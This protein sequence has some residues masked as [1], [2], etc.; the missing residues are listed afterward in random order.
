MATEDILLVGDIGGTNTRLQL[1][2][3]G[4]AVTF[5]EGK[6]MKAPG[7]LVH[8]QQY[9]NSEYA[10]FD[11]VVAAFMKAANVTVTPASACFAVAGPVEANR[12]QFTNRDWVIDGAKL[13]AS[14]G[15]S[16]VRLIN[17]FVAN[18]Y[19]LLTLD[20]ANECVSLQGAQKVAGAPIACIGAGTGL[21]ECFSTAVDTGAPYESYP[22]EGGHAE[23]SP[24]S[25]LEVELLDFMKA[26]FEQKHRVSVERVISGPGLATMYEFFAQR[27][28]EKVVSHV[29]ESIL[30]A[31]EMKGKVIS[32][33]ARIGAA[34]HCEL[35][36]LVMETFASAYG[37]EAGVAA[38]KWIPLGGLYIAGGLTPKNLELIQ[39]AGSPFMRAF[40]DKGRLSP[41][42]KRVPVYAVLAEDIGQ[43]GAHLVAFRLTRTTGAH[44]ESRAQEAVPISAR[45]LKSL[46]SLSAITTLFPTATQ[47]EALT[48]PLRAEGLALVGDIGGTN[49][50]L[51]LYTI[52]AGAVQ[53]AGARA[54]GTLVH[55]QQ[56]LNSEY[57]SFDAVVAAFMKA[58]N[59][60][61]TPASACFAVAG[62]VE[63]NRVQFTNRDWVIDGAKLEASL[64]ISKVRLINDFVANGYG[65]LTLDEANECVSLQGAQ[66][67]AGAPIACIGAGTGL[68][69]CF[70]T[71]VDTGAP[72]ESYPSEG[73]HAEWSPRSAL[74]VELLDFMKAKFEQKHRVSVERVISGPGLATMYEFF[75]QR[76]PEKVV[77]HVHESILA[78]GEMKGKVISTH[79]RIGAAPHC[80]LCE[81]VMETFA[82]AYGAEAGVAALKWIPLGGLYIA[83]GLTPKNLELIQGAGSPFMRAFHDKGRLSPLLKR[84]PVYAVLAEDIGQRGAHL[85]AFRLLLKVQAEVKVPPMLAAVGRRATSYGM[86]NMLPVEPTSLD[87]C[88]FTTSKPASFDVV[89]HSHPWKGSYKR[90]IAVSHGEIVTIDPESGAVTNRWPRLSLLGTQKTQREGIGL[91]LRM[92]ASHPLLCGMPMPASEL[93]LS[94]GDEDQRD[95]LLQ[96]L[97]PPAPSPV[98]TDPGPISV[99]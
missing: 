90:T 70:S 20:E 87:A 67:V 1:F 88:K 59:V 83:G 2:S 75:A 47:P 14:L 66:K 55:E 41:L 61:V 43:R 42:L 45:V 62:P 27:F 78:A 49:T 56:Y 58:A 38:L 39:G 29:H 15:I 91:T 3:V 99:A 12:V 65:L 34:P 53:F 74:E 19:G 28:P 72:Y 24:R 48:P 80:E 77:S 6:G 86:R 81:L 5:A 71:A 60:T 36:E 94:L 32:T 33:H 63:A 57:A 21:G 23:W 16:K 85:V 79:A 35:C 64:G 73:G 31:G 44:V 11:A 76:F 18:G 92:D 10:S 46:S 68:G 89:K 97:T 52:G 8:E 17:D 13:E 30:A 93:T 96:A 54:P 40:H 95:Q 98:P 7:T 69:E 51:Q 84:V 25:A 9:L 50:R 4:K 22:S 37:A 26:K 82:S